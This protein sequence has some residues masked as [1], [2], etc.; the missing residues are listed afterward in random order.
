MRSKKVNSLSFKSRIIY[1]TDISNI[2]DLC[3][4]MKNSFSKRIIKDIEL[5]AYKYI[6]YNPIYRGIIKDEIDFYKSF[7]HVKIRR[8]NN[9]F[10]SMMKVIKVYGRRMIKNEK[11]NQTNIRAISGENLNQSYKIEHIRM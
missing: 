10:S 11:R 5:V 7:S 3:S 6:M 9:S 1:S 2:A 8:I 4:G